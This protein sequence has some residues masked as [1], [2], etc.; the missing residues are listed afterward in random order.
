M[1]SYTT[2]RELPTCPYCGEE[3]H[4]WWDG[5]EPKEDG[6]VWEITCGCGKPFKVMM[7]IEASFKAEVIK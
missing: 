6:D 4:D 7:S 2:W 3:L 1:R 5:L